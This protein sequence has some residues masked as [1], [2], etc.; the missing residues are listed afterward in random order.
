MDAEGRKSIKTSVL[1]TALKL[2]LIRRYIMIECDVR[3]RR[4]IMGEILNPNE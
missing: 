3:E 1:T 2:L 4:A